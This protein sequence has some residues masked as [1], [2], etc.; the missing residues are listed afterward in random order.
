VERQ[1]IAYLL[2]ALLIAG[3]PAI[4][5]L[6]RHKSQY[7]QNKRKTRRERELRRERSS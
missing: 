6:A 5:L 4:L 7:Q 3:I 2:I 1:L